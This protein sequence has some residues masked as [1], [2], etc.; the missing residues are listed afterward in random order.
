M[1][2][3]KSA[4]TA[5]TVQVVEVFDTPEKA[6]QAYDQLLEMGYTQDEINVLMSA[7]TQALFK[8]GNPV[9]A[10]AAGAEVPHATEKVLGGAGAISA[11]GALSGAIAGVGASIIVP[12]LGL[13]VAG[14]LAALGAGLGAAL[15]AMYGIPFSEMA[16]NEIANNEA[17]IQE[18]KNYAS[19]IKEGKILISVVPRSPEDQEKIQRVWSAI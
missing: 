13:L 9:A 2:N 19:R 5:E 14:P 11:A 10:N 4:K 7:E 17:K 3:A 6:E 15:G 8:S 18:G 1:V 16:G 12:G